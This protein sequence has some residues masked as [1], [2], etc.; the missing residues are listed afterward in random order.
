MGKVVVQQVGSSQASIFG[1]KLT[2]IRA[3][4]TRLSPAYVYDRHRKEL[5]NF[6]NMLYRGGSPITYCLRMLLRPFVEKGQYGDIQIAL[7]IKTEERSKAAVETLAESIRLLLG[8]VFKNHRWDSIESFEELEAF[9]NPLNWVEAN[10]VEYKR[11]REKIQL[12][13]FLP[14]RSVGFLDEKVDRDCLECKSIDYIHPFTANE[15]AYERLFRTLLNGK[16]QVV[17]STILSPTVL[18]QKESEFLYKQLTL[19]EGTRLPSGEFMPL[20]KSRA[21]GLIENLVRDYLVLQDMP[22][23]MNVILSTNQPLDNSILEYCG[24]TLTEPIGFGKSGKDSINLS[25]LNVGGYDICKPSTKDQQMVI[26]DN[27]ARL[28]QVNWEIEEVN[29]DQQRL[30]YIYDA[31]E[32]IT[33]FYFPVNAEDNLPGVELFTL[34]E[35]SLPRELVA[36]GQSR[37]KKTLIGVNRYSGYE[38]NVFLSEDTRRQHA[39]IV[40]QTGTGKTT[41][42]KT[43]IAS[44]M[45][46]GN[47]LAVIDPHGEFYKDLLSIVPLNRKD[48]VVLIDPSDFQYPVGLN[49]LEVRDGEE[50]DLVVK[51]LRA[52]FKRYIREFFEISSGEYY[53][54]VFFQHVQ[55][56]LLL[57]MSDIEN[58]GTIIEFFN[59]FMETDFWRRWLPLK[60]TNQQLTNWTDVVLPKT[61][62]NAINRSDGSRYGDYFAAK[63]M[64]FVN[65]TRIN[66]IFG[67][68]RSTIDIEKAVRDNKII[69]INLSKG[70]LGEANSTLLG[71]ILLA[72]ITATLMARAKDIS[73]DKKVTPFYLYVDEF[74]NIASENFSILLAEARK[75][76]LGLILANQYLS[77]IS[78]HKIRDSILGNV[79][80]MIS[81]RLGLEDAQ[82]LE[83][84]FLPSFSKENLCNLPNYNAV[85]RTNVDGERVVPTTFTTIR[86]N[87][88]TN[89]TS[90][91][92]L[93]EGSR[94][95]YGTPRP[96]AE[97]IVKY[98][99]ASTRSIIIDLDVKYMNAI[100]QQGW[101][102]VDLGVMTNY[103]ANDEGLYDDAMEAIEVTIQSIFFYLTRQSR[104]S[105]EKAS[106]L[107]EKIIGIRYPDFYI[108]LDRIDDEIKVPGIEQV[109]EVINFLKDLGK[110]RIKLH[111]LRRA[112][113][114]GH[115]EL[116]KAYKEVV[117]L[118]DN[119]Q[120]IDA[121]DLL[122]KLEIRE[123]SDAWFTQDESKLADDVAT[124]EVFK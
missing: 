18:E 64:D 25:T 34:E 14:E 54:P 51:E 32:A 84:Q 88:P 63:F 65:D 93:R 79:G 38:Q 102:E 60:W 111:W 87:I 74:Q 83:S 55:S 123:Y 96:L 42:L 105:K 101:A 16:Q 116:R 76:G 6:I 13:N 41:L 49:L 82:I 2:G 92:S 66:N 43:M 27:L 28:N 37:R 24:L 33:G 39:Y 95:K 47:G 8:G 119:E 114:L 107:W 108:N 120:L 52:I 80:T 26:S 12:D 98:S 46:S 70:L 75:F 124:I 19:C 40:G 117:A 56:N 72:K 68:P 53:G 58:P 89:V 78:D 90:A 122:R 104:L 81:F 85:M 59:I 31:N 4:E 11:R 35:R 113:R 73:L 121:F 30:R 115:P 36:L 20:P 86:P 44:D 57:A 7:L 69:L 94:K 91:D 3:N 71:M 67:Q 112:A 17:W 61:D 110:A 48:D 77:Q 109:N 1:F 9:I 50:R 103:W 15:G 97:E 45:E 5:S 23:Y 106:L 99:L 29:A 118:Q 22:F 10:H 62:Y 100:K 21:Q